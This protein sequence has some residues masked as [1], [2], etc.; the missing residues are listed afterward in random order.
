MLISMIEQTG[1]YVV[2]S[3]HKES[4]VALICP[5]KKRA[6]VG[7]VEFYSGPPHDFAACDVTSL[8]GTTK[9]CFAAI[10]LPGQ[11]RK[12]GDEALAEVSS[13]I[14]VQLLR[15]H[16]T[17]VVAADFNQGLRDEAHRRV[18][19]QSGGWKAAAPDGWTVARSNNTMCCFDGFWWKA[20]ASPLMLLVAVP[21]LRSLLPLC[22]CEI[23]PSPCCWLLGARCGVGTT[24]EGS[25]GRAYAQVCWGR[26]HSAIQ[27]QRRPLPRRRDTSLLPAGRRA[28]RPPPGVRG[29]AG[30]ARAQCTG[31]GSYA[32]LTHV[33]IVTQPAAKASRLSRVDLSI[34]TLTLN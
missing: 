30:F 19:G 7:S 32:V 26:L 12:D 17:V 22:P 10:H 27:H 14:S 31:S 29:A 24:S 21:S 3:Y 33:K 34:R 15:H 1:V 28:Q 25:G 11:I 8:D 18:I 23:A 4:G 16:D 9:V 5:T 2:L 6:L 20:Q 13:S